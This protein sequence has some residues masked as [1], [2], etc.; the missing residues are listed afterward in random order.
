[1]EMLS[2]IKYVTFHIHKLYYIICAF[3]ILKAEN[4]INSIIPRTHIT[5]NND[6]TVLHVSLLE[7]A[8]KL[9][10]EILNIFI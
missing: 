1:M 5:H 2:S 6:H 10:N 8:S 7:A 4:F 3:Q 9:R